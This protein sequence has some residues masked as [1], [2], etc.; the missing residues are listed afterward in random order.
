MFDFWL[1]G[2]YNISMDTKKI[3]PCLDFKDGRVV[4]GVNFA[5]MRDA[6]DP[7][8]NAVFYE[9]E[10][11]DELAFLDIAATVEGR[12]TLTEAVKRVAANIRIPLT[13]GG[14]IRTVADAERILSAGAAK[15][16]IN[17]AAVKRP[18][19][20]AECVKKFGSGRVIVAI[21]TKESAPGK[22]NVYINGGTVDTGIDAVEWA[23]KA[24]SLGAGGL[25]PTSIDRDGA[26]TGYD[27]KSIRSIAEAVKIPVIASGGAGTKE[28]F[29][30]ALTDGK[31]SAALA[32]SLFHFRE[33]KIPELKAYL[34]ANNVA[35]SD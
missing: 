8:E 32:A 31:A 15:I 11:A 35:V 34:K 26:K 9:K 7:V 25:L 20:I 30:A 14:G 18:E 2:F 5:G 24:E 29:L 28:D 21:D 12:E 19:L 4:K 22:W 1:C 17:S 6:G 23:K 10:G 27:I 33:I 3:I 13:V 16:S